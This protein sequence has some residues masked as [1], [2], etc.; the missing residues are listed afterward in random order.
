[1]RLLLASRI[2]AVIPYYG[3]ARQDRSDFAR[4]DQCE[5]NSRFGDYGWS[6]ARINRRMH[7]GQIQGFRI[8]QST[9][10][11]RAC[12]ATVSRSRIGKEMSRLSPPMPAAWNAHV[13]LP[14]A[15]RLLVMTTNVAHAQKRKNS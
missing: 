8:S 13:L 1:M 7:A 12:L 9:T 15:R 14:T 2:N 11:F 6:F 5:I 10:F 4:A 3:Y